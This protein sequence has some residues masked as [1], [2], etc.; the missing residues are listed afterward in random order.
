MK[1]LDMLLSWALVAL[2]GAHFA[3]IWVPRLAMARG[4]WEMGTAV[5]IVTMGLMNAVRSGRKSDLLV[6]LA[7]LISTGMTGALVGLE[8]YHFTGNVL[9]QPA[10]LAVVQ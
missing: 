5:A 1:I 9:H 2:G 3:A 7:C 8:L 6:K 4:P 10:A